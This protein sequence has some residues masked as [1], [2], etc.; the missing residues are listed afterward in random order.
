MEVSFSRA[1]NNCDAL[2][3]VVGSGC[4][5]ETA[6]QPRATLVVRE[7]MLNPGLPFSGSTPL[8]RSSKMSQQDEP[9]GGEVSTGQAQVAQRLSLREVAKVEYKEAYKA[10]ERPPG[11]GH[12]F[13]RLRGLYVN[14]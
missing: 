10:F 6:A 12:A 5:A 4:F 3:K 1:A 7:M 14:L 13:G 2:R 9:H 11:D 8:L